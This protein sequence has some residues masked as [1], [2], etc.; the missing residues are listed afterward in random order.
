MTAGTHPTPEQ[1]A[2]ATWDDIAPLYDELARRPLAV[3]NAEAWLADWSILEAALWEA[4]NLASIAYATDTADPAKE[5]AHLRFSGEIG[6]QQEEEQVRLAA[7]LLDSGYT[8]PDL[9]TT[10]RRFQNQ[11]DLFRAENVPLEQEFHQLNAK[12]SKLTGGFT[13]PW[14]GQDLPLPRLSP[15]LLSP[16]RAVRE[17]AYRLREAPYIAHQAE[18]DEIFDRQYALRQQLARNAGFANYRD[19]AHQAKDRFDYTPADCAAFADAVEQV[20]V[21]AVARRYQR[22]RDQLGLD[23]LRPW[24]TGN[25]PLGRPALKPYEQIDDLIAGGRRIFDRV[26][27]QLGAYFEIMAEEG[28]L[29]LESRTG[30]RPGGFCTDL[31]Y[32][33]R[34]FIFMNASGVADN[35]RTL[36]H[37]SGHAFHDFE[38]FSLPFIF[39]QEYGSEIA[40][41]ASMSMELLAAPYLDR[42]DGGFYDTEEYRRAS[43]EHLEGILAIL[44]WIATIDTF[45]QWLYSSGDGADHAKRDAAWREIFGR[46]DAGL[47]W[48]GLEEERSARWYRQ[49]HIFL[50]PFYYIEYGIAQLGALQVWRN[51]LSDQAAAV[52]AYRTAL[53]LGGT[54]PLPELFAAAG[55]RF[56]FDAATMGELVN[57]IEE[58]L[59]QL[60]G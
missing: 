39:Q 52:A 22:R 2:N 16:D 31:A 5:A 12:Y 26:D 37:E 50:Y 55:A 28:L 44:P 33:K 25:D 4:K 46:F 47:D 7:R 11:R 60:E 17:R 42:A 41:V 54:Q 40:E 56:S 9:T 3:D 21:P 1:F 35:V 19:Y 23:T 51:S 30:K 36:L 48:S 58:Q 59:A 24:D 14:D 18:L 10:L 43:I 38:A 53:A 49:L 8:R 34:P 15:F 57:L 32:R 29:D 20:V 13:A 45:Q 6:P 27:R